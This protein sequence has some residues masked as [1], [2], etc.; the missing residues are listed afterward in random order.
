[1]ATLKLKLDTLEASAKELTRKALEAYPPLPDDFR[2]NLTLGIDF[3]GDD[4][5]FEL[6]IAGERPEDA[7]TLTSVTI[8]SRT[9]KAG[10]VQVFSE[11]WVK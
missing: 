1:M 7:I 6:Y 3:V 8:N 11:N 10:D 9:G 2:T 4:R 5:V